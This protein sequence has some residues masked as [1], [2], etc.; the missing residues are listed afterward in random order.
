MYIKSMDFYFYVAKQ[1]TN[2]IDESYAIQDF[3]D[4][5]RTEN[6]VAFKLKE[7]SI[8]FSEYVKEYFFD[9]WRIFP[10][11]QISNL[12]SYLSRVASHHI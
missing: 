2:E 11:R 7:M 9:I 8:D 3:P 5:F 12:S 4:E 6:W 1:S 10:F